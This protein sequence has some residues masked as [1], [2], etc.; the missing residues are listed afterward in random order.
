MLYNLFKDIK[1][2]ISSTYYILSNYFFSKKLVPSLILLLI[3]ILYISS[4]IL[5]P[6]SNA[7]P[8]FY[9]IIGRSY[10]RD[11]IIPYHYIFDHKPVFIYMFYGIWDFLLPFT[12]GK[13]TILAILLSAVFVFSCS[14]FGKY[15][16]IL[17]ALILLL[18]GAPFDPLSGNSEIVLISLE[19][20]C[21]CFIQ[22]GINK[23][24]EK[25][26]IFSG[27]L[28]SI[29]ININYLSAIC[30]LLPMVILIFFE[31]IFSF[32]RIIFFIIGNIIGIT[33]VFMPLIIAV[34]KYIENYFYLQ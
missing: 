2:D 29:V 11:G 22:M 9:T 26:Y 18:I 7:D 33:I 34:N 4:Y 6:F 23:N 21:F 12:N 1:K 19:A 32:K 31:G 27:V 30:L 20:V 28:S 13:F 15:N 3:S 17:A 8:A 10:L 5:S 25:Y 24:K 16:K 14:I